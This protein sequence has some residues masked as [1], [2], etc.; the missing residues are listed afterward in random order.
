[1]LIFLVLTATGVQP[2]LLGAVFSCID[3]FFPCILLY[4]AIEKTMLRELG[5]IP[6]EKRKGGPSLVVLSSK[7]VILLVLAQPGSALGM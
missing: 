5:K 2:T 6:L 1:M 7:H 4:E 3:R